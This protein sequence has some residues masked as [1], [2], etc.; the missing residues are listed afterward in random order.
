MRVSTSFRVDKDAKEEAAQVLKQ[1]GMSLSDGINL[2]LHQVAMTHGIPFQLKVPS[3]RMEE[4][5]KEL[6]EGKGKRF[7]SMEALRADL[8]Q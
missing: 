5:L 7:D 6:E 3:E 8:E 4:A 2:F 1:Y